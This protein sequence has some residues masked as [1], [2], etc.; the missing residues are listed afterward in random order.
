MREIWPY[1][2]LLRRAL[3]DVDEAGL[4]H[5]DQDRENLQALACRIERLPECDR[6]PFVAERKDR[7]GLV[8]LHHDR[9]P[10]ETAGTGGFQD[11]LART[12][13]GSR[14]FREIADDLRECALRCARALDAAAPRT[15]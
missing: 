7:Q 5:L 8:G 14:E 10:V 6:I 15:W 2:H 9:E 1:V 13:R 12:R 11:A 3:V 4:Q